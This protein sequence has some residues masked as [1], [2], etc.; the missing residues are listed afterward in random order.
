[1]DLRSYLNLKNVIIKTTLKATILDLKISP[2]TLLEYYG[3]NRLRT[4]R[5]RLSY[6]EN[7]DIGSVCRGI[8]NLGRFCKELKVLGIEMSCKT[9]KNP[10]REA[11]NFLKAVSEIRKLN[12]LSFEM[13]NHTGRD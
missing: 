13:M 5:L 6:L 9:I 4:L 3:F 2:R 12:E 10:K 8:R 1:M 7:H 11:I